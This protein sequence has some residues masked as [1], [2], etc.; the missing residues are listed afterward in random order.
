MQQTSNPARSTR[1]EALFF[2]T[3]SQ[4]PQAVA[5][6]DKNVVM[7]Y[8]DVAEHARGLSRSVRSTHAAPARI[9]IF[10]DRGHE[11]YIAILAALDAG[12][13]YVPLDPNHPSER[14]QSVLRQADLDV[15]LVGESYRE[16]FAELIAP[17]GARPAIV[18]MAARS[19]APV[20]PPAPTSNMAYLMFTSGSTGMPKGVP[21]THANAR[22]FLDGA[23]AHYRLGPDDRCSQ[24]FSLTFD[25]SVFDLFVAWGSGAAVHCLDEF[26]LLDPTGAVAAHE[27]TL[28]FSV[29]SVAMLALRRQA[30][31]ADTMP[32]LRWS[33]FCGE[34]VTEGVCHTWS[35]AAPS[36]TV[37]NL[38]GPTEL[39]IACTRYVWHPSLD[40]DNATVASIGAPF[41]WLQA[42]I[43][44]DDG[45]V[46]DVGE[47]CVAGDQRFG[48]YWKNPNETAAKCVMIDGEP[49]Y[50]TGDR[51]AL[52]GDLLQF[53]GRSDGQI[54]L[55]GHRIELG[56]VEA[57][58]RRI[59]GVI[60][61]VVLPVQSDHGLT[62]K[63]VA[64]VTLREGLDLSA[65][66]LRRAA[67]VELP[68]SMLPS[69]F[70][71]LERLPLNAN[72]KIDRRTL[73][74]AVSA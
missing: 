15:V 72:G 33:L 52:V 38:Y 45:E 22:S 49:Y 8:A 68:A 74:Q 61:A 10:G 48:G 34:P 29:P 70:Y 65:R 5:I 6:V 23:I 36:S 27:L 21:I 69:Q 55:H 58:I 59:D 1:L 73:A 19:A 17:L 35:A 57:G 7:T 37:E 14:T 26:D 39:T 53:L 4:H 20:S 32:T 44:D 47:L 43:L 28:W 62:E 63:I 9:G 3:A 11:S 2:E 41:E 71:V 60:D 16:Q 64:T 67:A 30:L 18:S 66:Q 42:R 12:A 51:V 56:D 54:K 31:V 13:A 25:L 46:A 40:A 24:T 50:R